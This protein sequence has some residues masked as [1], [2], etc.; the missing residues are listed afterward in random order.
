MRIKDTQ[1]GNCARLGSELWYYGKF[2][3]VAQRG[4]KELRI[5]LLYHNKE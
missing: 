1:V 2:L 3:G 5:L 4:E